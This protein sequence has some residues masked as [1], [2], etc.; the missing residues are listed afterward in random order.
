A[1]LFPIELDRPARVNRRLTRGSTSIDGFR[2][3]LRATVADGCRASLESMMP[4]AI[5][6]VDDLDR[7]ARESL[8]QSIQ[9]SPDLRRRL[10]DSLCPSPSDTQG[11][12]HSARTSRTEPRRVRGENLAKRVRSSRRYCR[13]QMPRRHGQPEPPSAP[14]E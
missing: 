12:G 13:A 11:P 14:R 7:W 6:K 8:D 2:T 9:P 10:V 4:D 3:I 5:L 1:G